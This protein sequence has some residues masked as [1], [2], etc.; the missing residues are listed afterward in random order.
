MWTWLVLSVLAIG[1]S[2]VNFINAKDKINLEFSGLCRKHKKLYEC[3]RR[4][5]KGK[6]KRDSVLTLGTVGPLQTPANRITYEWAMLYVE[7]CPECNYSASLKFI[8]ETEA[9]NELMGR[10]YVSSSPCLTEQRTNTD[11]NRAYKQYYHLKDL[12]KTSLEMME[13]LVIC[14]VP[15]EYPMNLSP[16]DERLDGRIG[17]GWK[18]HNDWL[19][20][21]EHEKCYVYA[22]VFDELVVKKLPSCSQGT[23]VQWTNE[24]SNALKKPL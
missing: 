2:N 3:S 1:I 7:E 22:E 5:M 17:V 11:K 9:S 12:V 15:T 16:G 8:K 13:Q 21:R 19:G 10:Y 14:A 23:A 6:I 18:Q 20:E 4:G 24:H